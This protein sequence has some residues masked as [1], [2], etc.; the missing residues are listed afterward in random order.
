MIQPPSRLR[1]AG[2]AVPRLAFDLDEQ[3]LDVAG[4]AV[5][6]SAS[7]EVDF[8]AGPQL[9]ERLFAHIG[10]AQTLVLDLS[11]VTFIDSMAIGVLVGAA[12]RMQE[13]GTGTL[14]VVCSSENERVLR[15]FDI[16]GVTNL[17]ALHR[18]TPDALA[19]SVAAHCEGGPAPAAQAA[20]AVMASAAGAHSR[21]GAA[22]QY[23]PGQGTG[24]T[25]DPGVHQVDELA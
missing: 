17:I 4:A 20:A 23:S 9:R 13:I 25:S 3:L 18:S 21:R 2:Q 7:G 11:A 6:V 14:S 12:T 16:A 19:A 5:L 15:I 10:S 24:A 1:A 8:A 22:R